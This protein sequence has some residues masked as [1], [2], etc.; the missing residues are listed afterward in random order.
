MKNK[1]ISLM[2]LMALLFG[3]V[4]PVYANIVTP[5][6][7]QSAKHQMVTAAIQDIST[8]LQKNNPHPKPGSTGGEWLILGLARSDMDVPNTYYDTYYK[9]LETIVKEKQGVLHKRKYTEYSRTVLA[10]ASIGKDPG[11]VAGYNLL[12]PLEDVKAAVQQGINGA[13]FALLA[14]DSNMYESDAR[15]Q[16]VQYILEKELPNGGWTLS[17][18]QADLDVTAMAVQ[19][20]APYSE[21]VSVQKA[22][23]RAM[24]C[25]ST[26]KIVYCESAAQLLIA[27]TTLGMET[28]AVESVLDTLMA[29]YQQGKGFTHT[30]DG[31]VNAMATE[32][33]L[34]ALVAVER[35]YD[36][37][38]ALYDMTVVPGDAILQDGVNEPV[39]D[40][41]T[42]SVLQTILD[43]WNKFW[44]K[45]A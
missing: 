23:E 34:Y 38:K 18:N 15:Q 37:D 27:M 41:K 6:T 14:L 19:A 13:I 35:Y 24:N 22:I 8:V 20:L 26:G 9:S 44:R 7:E 30:L 11:N 3:I 4:T 21:D 25:L 40:A 17:G 32:Q 28:T 42:I 2:V 1:L 10:L 39:T 31:K 16:Y 12:Q 36:G 33:A 5:Q 29:F 43:K 45:G